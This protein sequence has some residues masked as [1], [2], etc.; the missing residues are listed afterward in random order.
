MRR[1]VS[2]N[3]IFEIIFNLTNI[4]IF[5]EINK[6]IDA[7]LALNFC[8]KCGSKLDENKDRCSNC[9]YNL[10]K[11]PKLQKT[12]FESQN[13][14]V[15][16]ADFLQR[17]LAWLID[18]IIVIAISSPL[19]LFL[20]FGSLLLLTNAY[21]FVVGFLYFWLLETFNN[22]QTLGKL[23]L[24]IRTVN[25]ENFEIADPS[26]YA[27]NNLTKATGFLVLDV[28]FGILFLRNDQSWQSLRI[29]QHLAHMVVI[30][31]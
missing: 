14:V 25:E 20:N 16:Y 29:T 5:K 1:L 17:A 30:R 31:A 7:T 19:S 23:L 2:I 9:G 22:G 3:I 24:K 4:I 21:N 12:T 27:L 10:T 15:E 18:I 28:I 13:S 26:M 11:R 8:P 6:K